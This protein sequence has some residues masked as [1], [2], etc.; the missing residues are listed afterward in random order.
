MSLSI[1]SMYS[2]LLGTNNIG[3]ALKPDSS[4]E[5]LA[6]GAKLQN[7]IESAQTDEELMEACKGFEQYFL[8]QIF[9]GMQATIDKADEDE[10][11]YTS[12][13]NDMLVEEYAKSAVDAQGYGVAKMLYES[14]KKRE[15]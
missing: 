15:A 14:M 11:E 2:S 1:D 7:T 12:M 10:N 5:G 9:K 8:E 3:S 4:L 6:A 13:F